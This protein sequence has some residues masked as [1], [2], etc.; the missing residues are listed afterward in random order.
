MTAGRDAPTAG[1]CAPCF[2]DAGFCKPILSNP[3]Q[4]NPI[5]LTTVQA[6]QSRSTQRAPTKPWAPTFWDGLDG[7][8]DGI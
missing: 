4:P 7:V 8:V 5:E 1:G 6:K 3:T 2:H